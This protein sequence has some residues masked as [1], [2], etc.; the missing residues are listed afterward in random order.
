MRQT[1]TSRTPNDTS[2]CCVLFTLWLSRPA[3]LIVSVEPYTEYSTCE[4]NNCEQSSSFLK[5][6]QF[7]VCIER[8]LNHVLLYSCNIILKF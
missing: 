1:T 4:S 5:P 7:Y 2:C 3:P 8:E 6:E